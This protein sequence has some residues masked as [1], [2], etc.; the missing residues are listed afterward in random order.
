MAV[1]ELWSCA[2][3]AVQQ[4][5]QAT[6]KGATKKLR[7]ANSSIAGSELLVLEF[8]LDRST[9]ARGRLRLQHEDQHHANIQA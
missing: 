5:Y 6:D 1:A 7:L 8:D 4:Q 9:S 2:R 3:D